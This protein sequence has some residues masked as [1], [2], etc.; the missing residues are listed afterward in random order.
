M[1]AAPPVTIRIV[2]RFEFGDGDV[3]EFPIVL[4]HASLGIMKQARASYPDWTE[5]SYRKCPNCPLPG[6]GHPRCPIAENLVGVVDAFRDRLSYEEVG[7]AVDTPARRYSKRTTLQQA[8]GSMIGIYTVA[9]GCPVLDKLRPML[10]THL[11]F[12]EPE[13]STYRMISMY[14]MAQYFRLKRGLSAD[15]AM[16]GFLSFLEEARQTNRAFCHRLQGLGIKDASLNA[17][18]ILNTLGEITSLQIEGDLNRLER[19]FSQ[20]YGA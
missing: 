8:L 18:A 9:S 15:W 7:V 6:E 3:L 10:A 2:Y 13:E 20:H 11:P 1:T 12:M 16:E 4:D 17:L 5:L 19:I 14:L